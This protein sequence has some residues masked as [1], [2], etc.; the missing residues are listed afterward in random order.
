MFTYLCKQNT[1]T[2]RKIVLI[3]PKTFQKSINF[4]TQINLREENRSTIHHV[5]VHQNI[6]Q[7]YTVNK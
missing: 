4:G 5:L 6:N 7:K 1:Q 3:S 2:M